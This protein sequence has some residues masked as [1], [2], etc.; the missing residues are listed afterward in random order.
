MVITIYC[1]LLIL[2]VYQRNLRMAHISC[3]LRPW[4]IE[5]HGH[6]IQTFFQAKLVS[7]CLSCGLRVKISDCGVSITGTIYF[8]LRIRIGVP[9][10]TG[11][12][13]SLIRY[14]V[15][16][17][18]FVCIDQ[19]LS[20]FCK[21]I[22]TT[23]HKINNVVG[24]N[25]NLH[26]DLAIFQRFQGTCYRITSKSFRIDYSLQFFII[27]GHICI[28]GLP[29]DGNVNDFRHLKRLSQIAH[30]NFRID[31]DLCFRPLRIQCHITGYDVVFKIPGMAQF[32]I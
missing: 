26:L 9:P 3:P 31:R 21:C 15:F 2:I 11:L 4:I 8:Q 30:G 10:S 5:S 25:E 19:K 32:F 16:H 7:Q 1:K 24:R 14:A 12:V 23:V 6:I 13:V 22:R 18:T 29:G 20:I 17:H 28:K 27:P